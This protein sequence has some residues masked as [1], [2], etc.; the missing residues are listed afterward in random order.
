[1][2]IY[3]KNGAYPGPMPYRIR[4]S[5]G[6][7]RTDPATF[8]PEE[9]ADVGYTAVA[10]KP[11]AG[12]YE[13]VEWN[14][15]DWVIESFSEAEMTNLISEQL[16]SI[17]SD[18]YQQESSPLV[19]TDTAGNTFFLDNSAA[20]QQRLVS[21]QSAVTGGMRQEG[22]VWKCAQLVN[23]NAS[24][25]FRSTA[26]SEISEWA[27]LAVTQVQACF[28]VE[29]VASNKVMAYTANADYAN[30]FAVSFATEYSLLNG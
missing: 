13:R 16:A 8:T 11:F 21:A 5:D 10:S 4:L 25:T 1:M 23:G 9:I 7:T 24:I 12:E 28:E 18:R 17:A 30:A 27:N 29:A 14:G 2:A 20:S 26:N 3:S 15:T 22:A 19:W 6:S